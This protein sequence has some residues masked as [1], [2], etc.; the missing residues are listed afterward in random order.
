MNLLLKRQCKTWKEVELKRI[1]RRVLA[2][3]GYQISRII[4]NQ[5]L[6]AT[7][8]LM[9]FVR[10]NYKFTS[11]IDIGV[12]EG[13]LIQ[14]LQYFFRSPRSMA[15]EPLPWRARRWKSA[16]FVEPQS[17]RMPFP[18]GPD[19]KLNVQCRRTGFLHAT[20]VC[21][22]LRRS[23]RKRASFSRRSAFLWASSTN[24]I[25]ADTLEQGVED[26][27]I[28]DGQRSSPKPTFRET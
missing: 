14:F 2:S 28:A 22:F 18:T 3:R 12:N 25:D 9:L 8:S 5:S 7:D 21:A 6:D 15:F 24:L 26:R 20:D 17:S 16:T 1:V 11:I 10:A 4:P 23:S 27:V 13:A 19:S